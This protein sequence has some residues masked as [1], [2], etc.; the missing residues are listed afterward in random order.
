ME[1]YN[2]KCIVMYKESLTKLEDVEKAI[3]DGKEVMYIDVYS[4]NYPAVYLV[5][6]DLKEMSN[7]FNKYNDEWYVVNPIIIKD[8]KDYDK[9]NYQDEYNSVFVAE[10][11]IS[12]YK[13]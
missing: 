4:S 3:K 8:E 5:L 10:I 12:K 6:D 2:K 1:N 11:K 9:L 13:N 7:R